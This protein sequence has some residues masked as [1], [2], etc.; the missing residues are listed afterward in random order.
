MKQTITLILIFLVINKGVGQTKTNATLDS[1]ISETISEYNIP[2][3][4]VAVIKPDSIYY[5]IQGSARIDTTIKVQLTDKYHIGSC[6]KAFTS[7]LA[8]KAIEANKISLD[9]KFLDLYPELNKVRNEYKDITLG[10]LLSHNAHLRPFTGGKEWDKFSKFNGTPIEKRYD[11]AKYVLKQK[12]VDSVAYSNAGYI[13][14]AMMIEKVNGLPFETVLKNTMDS[15]GIE[16]YYGFPNEEDVNFPWG[17]A[18]DKDE[19][20]AALPPNHY[21]KLA[22][23][24]L[25][26]GDLSINILDY[27]KF[28]QVHLN[29]F[30]G[31]D[32][33]LTQ[34]SFEKLFYDIESYS[35]GWA[36]KI[37]EEESFVSHDGSASTFY[38][39]TRIYTTK[40]FAQIVIMNSANSK[41]REGLYKLRNKLIK[42]RKILR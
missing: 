23:F 9:T 27:S 35:Y 2:S 42:T 6:T 31:N 32:S 25:P 41:Q 33:I 28:I 11:F 16:T 24:I 1:L 12:P 29:G 4:V 5:G 20:L 8:F 30:L 10:N 15:L 17:H 36:N 7:F 22:D 3:M 26:A 38:C 21:W 37:N 19:N 13:L 18:N 39:E 34:K 40:E 14:A